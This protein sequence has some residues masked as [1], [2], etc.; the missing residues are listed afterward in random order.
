MQRI[1]TL[2]LPVLLSSIPAANAAGKVAYYPD[3]NEN[4]NFTRSS[5]TEPELVW[6]AVH[7]VLWR[8]DTRKEGL[9]AFKNG[10]IPKGIANGNIEADQDHDWRCHRYDS[11]RSVFVSTSINKAVA[12]AALSWGNPKRDGWVYEIYAPGGIDQNLSVGETAGEGEAEISFPGGIKGK[13]I[14]Q[15]CYYIKTELQYCEDNK[16]FKAPSWNETPENVA[17]AK[18]SLASVVP[19][20]SCATTDSS[21]A[22]PDKLCPLPDMAT[23]KYFQEGDKIAKEGMYIHYDVSDRGPQKP[24]RWV[25]LMTGDKKSYSSFIVVKIPVTASMPDK[26]NIFILPEQLSSPAY[27]WQKTYQRWSLGISHT[28]N[29]NQIEGPASF[30]HTKYAANNGDVLLG[31]MT[32]GVMTPS[33]MTPEEAEEGF[34]VRVA[35]LTD[36][37]TWIFTQIKNPITGRWENFGN[38][39]KIKA[40][41]NDSLKIKIIKQWHPNGGIFRIGL[42]ESVNSHSEVKPLGTTPII[43]VTRK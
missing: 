6:R 5:E 29:N 38:Y 15:A 21:S 32:S 23:T 1:T 41:F 27:L 25:M 39:Q 37:D 42:S 43:T 13:F 20:A 16:N 24:T 31:E 7:N 33:V 2:L 4:F 18:V 14:K 26:G 19:K 8:G 34:R 12:I 9:G 40:G 10:L 28:E 35:G 11:F 36:R 17:A 30:M 22:T 3:C